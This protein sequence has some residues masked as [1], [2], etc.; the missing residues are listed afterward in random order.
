MEAYEKLV[1]DQIPE[2]LDAK[3]VPYEMHIAEDAEYRER[4]IDKLQEEVGEFVESG[5]SIEELA[6]LLEVIRALKSLP[7]YEGVETVA[8]EKR[9]E[10]GGFDGRVVV[11]G[12][13]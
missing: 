13:K 5:G 11:K 6:D 10:R 2:I 3:G 8:D 12:E 1:R 4:L 7:E 9:A